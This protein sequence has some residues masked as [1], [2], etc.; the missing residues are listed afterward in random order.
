MSNTTKTMPAN[1]K[2]ALKTRSPRKI[3]V[4]GLPEATIQKR[5]E[6]IKPL[7]R[8]QWEAL[9]AG[10]SHKAAA[11][12]LKCLECTCDDRE[13]ITTCGDRL[14]PLWRFRPFQVKD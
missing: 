11:L 1:C 10:K 5:L 6:A 7:Y 13:A 2:N 12:K 4:L 9:Y 14:C 8:S 3:A